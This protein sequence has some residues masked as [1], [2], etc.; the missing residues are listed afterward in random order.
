LNNKKIR[1]ATLKNILFLTLP[2]FLLG[3]FGIFYTSVFAQPTANITIPPL[4]CDEVM[5][6]LGLGNLTATN[7][8]LTASI[9][10]KFYSLS[11]LFESPH[12]LI[13]SGKT[14]YC[15]DLWQAFV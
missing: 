14:E 9:N 7:T 12:T 1:L 5:K 15:T 13:L 10:D 3:T 4:T 6:K 2:I 11:V 8:N